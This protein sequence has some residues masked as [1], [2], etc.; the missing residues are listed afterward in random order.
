MKTTTF[1]AFDAANHIECLSYGIVDKA[2]CNERNGSR[3]YEVHHGDNVTTITVDDREI[4]IGAG[5]GA[6]ITLIDTD[7]QGQ[8]YCDIVEM[9]AVFRRTRPIEEK[10]LS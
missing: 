8:P 5:G 1:K 6:N 10:D 7:E 3:S 4:E 2:S 9:Y